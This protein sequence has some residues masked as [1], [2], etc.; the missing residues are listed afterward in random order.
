MYLLKFSSLFIEKTNNESKKAIS[1]N[2]YNVVFVLFFYSK[3]IM[4]LQTFAWLN[5]FIYS[6]VSQQYFFFDEDSNTRDVKTLYEP[7]TQYLCGLINFATHCTNKGCQKCSWLTACG[8]FRI[9]L[10]Q[11]T[12]T[13]R[14][15]QQYYYLLWYYNFNYNC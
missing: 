13:Q 15:P 10:S 6:L 2:L 12:V 7:T 11:Y 4:T 8:S 3:L 14:V 1:P 5:L 9:S